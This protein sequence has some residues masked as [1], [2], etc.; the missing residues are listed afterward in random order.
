MISA[1]GAEIEKIM[2]DLMI[3]ILPYYTYK[4]RQTMQ[5]HRSKVCKVW[6]VTET[7][8]IGIWLKK[9]IKSNTSPPNRYF[10]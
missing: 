2:V 8:L 3:P 9:T 10:T 1:I 7:I 4:I 5:T 6:Y